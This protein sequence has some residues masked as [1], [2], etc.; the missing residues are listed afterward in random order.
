MSFINKQKNTLKAIFIKRVDSI[1]RLYYRLLSD[2]VPKGEPECVQPTLFLGRGTIEFG[3]NVSIGLR[4]S[5]QYYSAYTYFE[6]RK[7][8]SEIVIGNNVFFNNS[9][10]FICEN[11]SIKIGDDCLIGPCCEFLDSNFH[12][13]PPLERRSGTHQAKSITLENNVFLGANVI[14]LKGVTIGEN[15]V[16]G[17]NSVVVSDVPQNTLVSGNPA[18]IIKSLA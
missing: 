12:P 5:K 13:L 14:V 9:C 11:S 7:P 16:V 2:V 3:T 17:A 10:T 1:R 8:N 4:N 18:K 15:S 6:A